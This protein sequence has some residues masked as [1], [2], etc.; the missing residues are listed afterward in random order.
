[1]DLLDALAGPKIAISQKACSILH[2]LDAGRVRVRP[3]L[4]F[5]TH[6]CPLG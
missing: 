2:G 4:T 5:H 6:G 1:M 3:F